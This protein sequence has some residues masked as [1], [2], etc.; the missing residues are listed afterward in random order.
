MNII[1]RNSKNKNRIS[2]NG[3]VTIKSSLQSANTQKNSYYVGLSETEV[4]RY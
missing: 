3:Q 4:L 2:K 1:F